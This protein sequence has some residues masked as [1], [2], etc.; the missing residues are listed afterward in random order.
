MKFDMNTWA[1]LGCVLDNNICNCTICAD[2]WVG[3]DKFDIS[4]EDGLK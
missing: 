3:W 1:E 2:H 4:V